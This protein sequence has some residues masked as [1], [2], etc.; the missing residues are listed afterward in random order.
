MTGSRTTA[1]GELPRLDVTGVHVAGVSSGGYL[2][3]QLQVAYS[4]TVRGAAVFSAGP[5]GCAQG[6]V[7]V[8]LA[9]CTNDGPPPPQQVLWAETDALA[10]EGRIDP[11]ANLAHIPTY[12]FHGTAD[13]TVIT[14]VADGLADFYRHYRVP[15]TYRN[16]LPAGHGWISPLG[17]VACGDTASP[18]LNDC[19]GYDAQAD[20]LRTVF[21]SVQPPAARAGGTLTAV[22]QDRYAVRAVPGAGDVTRTGAAAIG[23]G[24]TGYLYMPEACAGGAPCRLVVALH[25]C[26]QSAEQIGT[27]FVERSGLNA[28]ADTNRFVVLYPQA[29]PDIGTIVNPQGCWD[30]WGYLGPADAGYATKHG[31]QMR[32]VMAMV[33]ALGG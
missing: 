1:P 13:R 17:P 10:R 25:G 2:A 27:T 11:T 8:A 29:R 18:Y 33:H 30:W 22:D 14:P 31:A 32:T 28:Y 16:T 4:A 9:N 26:L 5:Y 19:P 24:R 6:S 12:L 23:M 20:L 21:G 7:V 3:T 15:L